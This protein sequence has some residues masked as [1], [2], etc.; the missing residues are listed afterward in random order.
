VEA[1]EDTQ[2]SVAVEVLQRLDPVDRTMLPQVGRSWLAV[3]QAS[4][5]PCF[6]KLT[7]R[8]CFERPAAMSFAWQGG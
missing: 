6:S 7:V 4:G 3:T 2:T 1:P 8:L 5:I